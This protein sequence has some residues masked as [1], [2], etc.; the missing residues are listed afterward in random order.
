MPFSFSWSP[1]WSASM[2]GCCKELKTWCPNRTAEQRAGEILPCTCQPEMMAHFL[3]AGETLIISIWMERN[4]QCVCVFAS[5]SRK[6]YTYVRSA[7]DLNICVHL[8]PYFLERGRNDWSN[9]KSLRIKSEVTSWLLHFLT[10]WVFLP[11]CQVDKTVEV[12]LNRILFCTDCQS[13]LLL[14]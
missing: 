4:L 10:C 11:C 3:L 14:L 8:M 5:N 7:D 2:P 1:M 6:P 12:W 9:S 13:C